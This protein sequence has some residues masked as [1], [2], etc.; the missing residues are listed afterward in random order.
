MHLGL[1]SQLRAGQDRP[2][3]QGMEPCPQRVTHPLAPEA[4][5]VALAA[6]QHVVRVSLVLQVQEPGKDLHL[7]HHAG[8]A[9]RRRF[10]R[11]Q[12]QTFIG[13]VNLRQLVADGGK[14]RSFTGHLLVVGCMAA[15]HGP[16]V[17]A[18]RH[19]FWGKAR[20]NVDCEAAFSKGAQGSS[21]DMFE[22]L[23]VLALPSTEGAGDPDH[24]NRYITP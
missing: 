10:R 21:E 22:R 17:V 16:V 19:I 6:L 13:P 2:T 23:G 18:L 3:L 8:A 1:A 24:V 15:A 4:L 14:Q 20:D 5:E 7:G 11:L 12:K 9:G